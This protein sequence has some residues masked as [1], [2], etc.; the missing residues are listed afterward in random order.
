MKA[1]LAL[2]PEKAYGHDGI[3]S[4]V[5]K[6]CATVLASSLCKLFN[7]SLAIAKIPKEWKLANIIP[8]FK[9]GKKDYV[10]NYR[11]IS[12]LPIVS[13][14]FERCILN[15]LLSHIKSLLH[16]AQH[17]F[18]SGKSCT[19]QLLSALN[20]IGENLDRGKETDVVFM[21]MSK[22]FDR[23]DHCTLLHRLSKFGISGSLL[24]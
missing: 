5:L 15:H 14:V 2:D 13:K 4:R 24:D 10:E 7:K 21:D 11:P 9:S 12:L 16:P 22:A 3:L 1:L 20:T 23:V 8:I 6:E 18:V 19:T 17:G